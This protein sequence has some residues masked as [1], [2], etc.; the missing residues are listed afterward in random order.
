[1]EVINMGK[2]ENNKA[3]GTSIEGKQDPR[4]I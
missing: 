4:E 1:M 3:P 2:T